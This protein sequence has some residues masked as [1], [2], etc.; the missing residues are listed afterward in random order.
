MK[1]GFRCLLAAAAVAV[2]S[3]RLDAA[4]L[5]GP[6]APPAPV[7]PELKE[8][9]TADTAVTTRISR[10][11]LPVAQQPSYLGVHLEAQ[12]LGPPVI[13][14]VEPESPAARAGL[15]PGDV[16][17]AAAGQPLSTPAA[18]R[19]L[20]QA[21]APGDALP[22]EVARR[23][24]TLTLTAALAAT[25]RPLT[26]GQR[27]VLGVQV[28]PDEGKGLRIASVTP[29]SPAA[30]ARLRVDD[31]I[32]KV[33]GAAVAGSDRLG[34]ALGAHKPGDVVTLT[35]RRNDQTLDVKARLAAERTPDARRL[36]WDDRRPTYF[37][38][39]VYR[40]AVVAVEYPDVKH[41]DQVTVKDWDRALFSRQL[42]TDRSPTGQTVYGS[43]RDYYEEQS[44]GALSVEGKVFDYVQVRR[45]RAEYGNDGNRFALLTEAL[46]KLLAR[47]GPDALKDFDG[48]FFLYAGR[49]VQARRGGLYWP[50]R[51]SVSY[52]GK[53][54]AYFIC[55]EGGE[56]MASI[57]VI[58]H[59]FGHLLGL[60][61]LYARPE[62]P[63]SEGL[64]VW[65]TMS[66]GHGRDGKPLHFSAWCKEQLG[67]LR[68]AVIDPTVKQKLILAPVENAC[69]ECFKVLIRPDGSEYL[70][71]ENRVRKHFDRDLPAEGLLIWRVVD[72]RPVLEESH[73]ITTPDGP[74]RFLGSVPYP[75]PSNNAF[76]PYT[77]PSS[78]STK[79]HGLPVHITNIRRLPDG[80]VTF[81]V[82]YE[83]L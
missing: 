19:E 7:P 72:G 12:P 26:P 11:T 68:P 6:P 43:L 47:E 78:Q 70:L 25:S 9:R 75:S 29:G 82:G 77:T 28:E 80:R 13:A 24:K 40:L 48:L 4:D 53:R 69:H 15:K 79:G 23:E 44:C 10:S 2:L 41:N 67:W 34:A 31:L 32:V 81:F 76:T 27:A 39:P 59:E 83:Y 49:G 50:H 8:F 37:R 73:G 21:R 38:K 62:D 35:V 46:D 55:P 16:L 3:G 57:S 58:A 36:R 74:V 60:P 1:P 66:T 61:D 51:A 63:G 20:L 56:R 71:L 52:R 45:Q 30:L 18:L 33:D 54:W 5:V 42:Y 17:R 14:A 64:G 22:L 65:C